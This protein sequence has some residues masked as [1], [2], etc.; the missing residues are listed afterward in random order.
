M[1]TN[2]KVVVNEKIQ[3][4]AKS[5]IKNQMNGD[6]FQKFMETGNRRVSSRKRRSPRKLDAAY[7]D[8]K[9]ERI[10]NEET[11]KVDLNLRPNTIEM[12]RL[13]KSVSK[14]SLLSER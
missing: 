13:Y 9:I 5:G 7:I 10:L 2:K 3:Q 1:L 8:K 4:K 11:G 6:L 12:P 14:K